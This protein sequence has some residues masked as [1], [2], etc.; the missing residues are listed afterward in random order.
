MENRALWEEFA[1]SDPGCYQTSEC[2]ICMKG[3]QLI[4]LPNKGKIIFPPPHFPLHHS[5]LSPPIFFSA[6]APQFRFAV[7]TL[8][9][10]LT[11]PHPTKK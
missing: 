5:H 2:E 1:A 9:S 4:T 3:K 11:K 8:F 6:F 10:L 7:P